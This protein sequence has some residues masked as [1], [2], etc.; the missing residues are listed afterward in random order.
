MELKKFTDESWRIYEDGHFKGIITDYGYEWCIEVNY[1]QYDV[2]KEWFTR[3]E[4]RE[5]VERLLSWDAY[6]FYSEYKLKS[7][8]FNLKG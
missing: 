1:K 5:F 4:L 3:Q 8:G 7:R 6:E 2:P